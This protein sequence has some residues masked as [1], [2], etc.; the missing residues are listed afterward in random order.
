MSLIWTNLASKV[1]FDG[2]SKSLA[3]IMWSYLTYHVNVSPLT[4]INISK[5][6]ILYIWGNQRVPSGNGTEDRFDQHLQGNRKNEIISMS[7][8]WKIWLKKF[9]CAAFSKSL[10]RKRWSYLTYHVH[11][12]RL[13]LINIFKDIIL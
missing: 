3:R 4:L 10:A 11:V 8:I 6:I 12:S 5:D 2:F 13:T 9:I 1:H 7:L